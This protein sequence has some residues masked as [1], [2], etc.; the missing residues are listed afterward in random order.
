MLKNHPI[1]RER[2]LA[3]AAFCAIGVGGVLAVDTMVTGGFDFPAPRDEATQ[4]ARSDYV[5]VINSNWA[6]APQRADFALRQTARANA[7]ATTETLDGD[8]RAIAQGEELSDEELYAEID[9]LY[10]AE[11][12]ETPEYQANELADEKD[13]SAYETA[14]PW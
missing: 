10:R 8:P 3:A 6:P 7:E 4:T 11:T 13:V 1:L 14:S 9:A 12:P 5:A 2:L